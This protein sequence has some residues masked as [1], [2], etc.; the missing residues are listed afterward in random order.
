MAQQYIYNT[1]YVK[2]INEQIYEEIG[3]PHN[4]E[5]SGRESNKFGTSDVLVRKSSGLRAAL[6][7]N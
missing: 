5:S 7:K 3:I 2:R 1:E 4:R 6:M